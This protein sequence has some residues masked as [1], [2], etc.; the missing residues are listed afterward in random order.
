MLQPQGDRFE[1]CLVGRKCFVY[2]CSCVIARTPKMGDGPVEASGLV[3]A[4]IP[5]YNQEQEIA[6][7]IQ[8][9]ML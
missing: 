5:G 2:V 7:D 4:S 8:Q 9:V 1:S 6:C 3:L